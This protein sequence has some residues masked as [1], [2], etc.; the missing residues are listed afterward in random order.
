[1]LAGTLQEMRLS[2]MEAK[3]LVIKAGGQAS[4]EK[5]SRLLSRPAQVDVKMIAEI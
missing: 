4:N 1:M 3:R 5:T 2:D